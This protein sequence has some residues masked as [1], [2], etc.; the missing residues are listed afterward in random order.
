[1]SSTDE[2]RFNLVGYLSA[3]A[4]AVNLVAV[5]PTPPSTDVKVGD[6][7]VSDDDADAGLASDVLMDWRELWGNYV[8]TLVSKTDSSKSTDSSLASTNGA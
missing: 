2:F 6:E 4:S 1:M 3:N 7:E 5:P 8:K